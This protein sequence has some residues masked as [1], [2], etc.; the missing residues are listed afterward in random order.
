MPPSAALTVTRVPYEESS[1]Y[2]AENFFS[3]SPADVDGDRY[4][5]IAANVRRIILQPGDVLIV[6]P[7]WWH[8]AECQTISLSVNSWIPLVS[9]TMGDGRVGGFM[10]VF[11]VAA[12]QPLTRWPSCCTTN[13]A[14][15]A[16]DHPRSP[17]GAP[18]RPEIV[19]RPGAALPVAA[20]TRVH[21]AGC[22]TTGGPSLEYAFCSWP[23]SRSGD[24][25]ADGAQSCDRNA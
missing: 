12:R 1:V 3:P 4:A 22:P 23:A 11:T 17:V 15:R 9:E 5:A 13:R 2:C 18:F 7:K 21:A 24:R 14:A 8:Y 20:G 16:C 6:P 10:L 25:R 19:H